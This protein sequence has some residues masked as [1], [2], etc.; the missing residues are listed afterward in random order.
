MKWFLIL[1]LPVF[2]LASCA[3]GGAV[4]KRYVC[5]CGQKCGCETVS[6]TPGKCGCG[7][8]LVPQ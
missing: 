5:K 8:D 6:T 7:H 1:A 3:P 4:E 2:A